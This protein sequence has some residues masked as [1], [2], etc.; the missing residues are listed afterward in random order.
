MVP[1]KWTKLKKRIFLQSGLVLF[2]CL[3]INLAFAAAP[4][5][6]TVSPSSGSAAPG[7]YTTFTCAYSDAD[8]WAN[9]KEAHFLISASSAGLTN[10]AYL[11]YNQNANKIYLRNDT[12]TAWL[13]GYAPGSS[14][15]I[16]NS[17]A[18]IMCAFS[19]ASGS[20]T[21]LT[22]K[23]YLFFKPAYSGK[24]YNSYLKAVDDNNNSVSWAQKGSFTVNN[25]PTVGTVMPFSGTVKT[26]TPTTFTATFTDFD[27]WQN[28][29]EAYLL[30]NTST[31][32]A[33]CVY[34]YYNQNTSLLYLRNEANT[35]WL[36]GFAPGSANIIQNSYASIDCSKTSISPNNTIF[37]VNWNI[38]LKDAFIG[39]KNEY[40]YVKDDVN[41]SAGW[42]QAGSLTIQQGTGTPVTPAVSDD[43]KYTSSLSTLHA[44][45]TTPDTDIAE[46]QYGIGSG[47]PG[48][49]EV[50]GWTSTTA[51]EAT[52]SG[53]N[54][55]VG[56]TYFFNVKAK[57]SAGGWSNVGSSD[58][59]TVDKPPEICGL[60]PVDKGIFLEGD[61]IPIYACANFWG[62]D[63]QEFQVSIDSVAVK[64]WFES[65]TSCTSC[66]GSG[67][68]FTYAWQTKTGDRGSHKIKV[69]ARDN[70]V[71]A[72][73]KE[74]NVYVA[75]KPFGPP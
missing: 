64:P 2:F 3:P 52:A 38:T 31:S 29:Q 13:G 12:N 33:N 75:G 45:W 69:E 5:A 67:V 46:F 21:A 61:V 74:I 35:A 11:Y 18:K 68:S 70:R 19:S 9:L 42:T 63:K 66:S 72:V 1:Q 4:K 16:E 50:K 6:G 55:I 56:A 71:E 57:N 22:I 62:A 10:S 25:K 53:L 27:G 15:T 8:G 17:Q 59:I 23:F 51:K 20:G 7:F 26:K 58:G 37:S 34:V 32:G 73:S 47:F 41:D 49:T 14:G 65:L 43:G 36:G 30:L 60:T 48:G 40:L 24:A 44:K 54:L 28:L 39:A